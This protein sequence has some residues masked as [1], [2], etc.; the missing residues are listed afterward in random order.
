MG[1]GCVGAFPT[2]A[3]PELI[4]RCGQL[5]MKPGQGRGSDD[6]VPAV[7]GEPGQLCLESLSQDPR[8]QLG[9]PS[10]AGAVGRGARA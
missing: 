7:G 3:G 8:D 2:A 6:P 4:P 9:L 5:Q 10:L 1:Q